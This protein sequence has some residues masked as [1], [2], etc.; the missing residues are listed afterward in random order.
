MYTKRALSVTLALI[1]VFVTIAFCPNSAK[2]IIAGE[3]TMPGRNE[4]LRIVFENQLA[5]MIEWQKN[6]FPDEELNIEIDVIRTITDFEGNIYTIAECKP[7]GYMIYHNDSGNF[8]EYSPTAISPFKDLDGDLRYAGPNEYYVYELKE[9]AYRHIYNKTT[10]SN[11]VL[12]EL[13]SLSA[14]VDEVLTNRS[15]LV[16]RNYVSGTNV[17]Q[18][19]QLIQGQSGVSATEV[20]AG[21][22]TYVNNYAFFN[23]LFNCGYTTVTVDGEAEGICG[24]IAAGMLLVYDEVT[25]SYNT[26]EDAFYSYNSVTNSY[27]I[28]DTLPLSLYYTGVRLGYGTGTT[29]VAIHY[30]VKEWL[31]TRNLSVSHTSLFRP[32]ASDSYIAAHI[33][34][35]RPVIWFGN[36]SLN[37]ADSQTNINHAIVVYGYRYI[38]EQFEFVAHFGWD[39]ATC[40]YFI[41]I[42]GSMYSYDW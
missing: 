17:A 34:E 6:D 13:H 9:N 7:T 24:Y 40:V 33:L 36:V 14:A 18:Y 22:W 26:V 42:L 41:G 12:V 3:D 37:T 28:N 8:V 35:D 31:E 2:A 30:T 38:N 16:V 4:R 39:N 10:I 32:F 27:T 11:E 5:Q 1:M 29:S 20:T 19:S 21:S 23:N 15:N 25:N